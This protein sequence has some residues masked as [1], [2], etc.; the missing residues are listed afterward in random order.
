PAH[1]AAPDVR[2]ATASERLAEWSID[3]PRAQAHGAHELGRRS[4]LC[5]LA[6]ERAQSAGRLDVGAPVEQRLALREAQPDRVGHVLP[7]RLITV[8]EGELEPGREADRM[9]ADRRRGDD[10][11]I[12]P[13]G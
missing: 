2:A 7:T 4:I 1:L 8:K 11:G 3:Q 12:G 6:G 13:P 9:A 10:A 5:C